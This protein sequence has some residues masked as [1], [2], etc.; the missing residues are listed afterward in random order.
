MMDFINAHWKSIPLL[1]PDGVDVTFRQQSAQY[2]VR[3]SW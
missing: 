2:F 3:N 1:T